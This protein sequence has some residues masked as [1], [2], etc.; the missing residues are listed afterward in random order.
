[1]SVGVLVGCAAIALAASPAAAQGI[2]LRSGASV[3]PDQFSVGGQYDL[4][5]GRDNVWFQP[6]ADLGFGNDTFLTAL[7]FDLM[8]R[9]PVRRAPV[10]TAFAGGGPALNHYRFTGFSSTEAGANLVGGL[11]HRSGFFTELR[12]GFFDS[13][14]LRFGAGYRLQ[15]RAA[16]RPPAAR[17]PPAPRR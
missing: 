17:R 14:E 5:T 15:S 13:P 9:R 8:Y 7:N 10:W 4:E 11:M 2:G 3:N 1:V 16:S 12:L 6:S